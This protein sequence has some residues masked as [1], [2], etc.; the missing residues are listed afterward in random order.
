MQYG[1]RTSERR[2]EQEEREEGRGAG[3]EGRQAGEM[4]QGRAQALAHSM[5]E[6]EGARFGPSPP[7]YPSIHVATATNPHYSSVVREGSTTPRPLQAWAHREESR[8]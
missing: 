3:Q 5:P 6:W 1:G 7:L 2:K 8:V 4:W